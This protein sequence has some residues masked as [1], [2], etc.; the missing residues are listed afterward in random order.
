[1]KRITFVLIATMVVVLSCKKD[2]M[3]DVPMEQ[4]TLTIENV[5][6]PK[7]FFDAG[8]TDGIPPGGSFSFTFNAGKGH[9]LSFATMLA[10]SNDLFYAFQEKGIALYDGSGNAVTGNVT[11]KVY[12]WD[13]GT[14]VNEEPGTGPNQAPR[15]S[16]PD[17]GEDEDGNVKLISDV[18]DGF[19]YPVV[20]GVIKVMISHDGG[21]EFTVTIYN[22]SD[23]A[24]L[25]SPLAPGVW[26]VHAN[27]VQLFTEG[28]PSSEGLEKLAEDGNNS[29]LGDFL[30][31]NAGLVSPFAPGVYAVY[32]GMNPI[33]IPGEEASE[34]LEAL[35]ED[36]DVSMFDFSGK[37]T[38]SAWGTFMTPVD[39]SGPGPVFPGQKYEVSFKASAG[40]VLSF[41]TML[42][43]TNDVFVAPEGISLFGDGI[44]L[45]GD[46]TG[47]LKLW[48][49]KT[50]ANEYPGAG[51]YQA[52]R[53]PGPNTGTDE[54]GTVEV[55]NDGYT[56]P[57]L[58]NMI[59]VTISSN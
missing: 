1:M 48:D 14:E 27:D 52:P 51:M 50:E 20:S 15:Q 33:F 25:T 8:T 41:A 9:Y 42:V 56:Y 3:D 21:T 55:V 22:M 45:S 37:P 59:R 34:A 23:M 11:D 13:A 39:G 4:F 29:T 47:H 30:K 31:M 5:F 46:I 32:H 40:E 17:T 54:T 12:L 53:Q 18:N 2:G 35:A 16:G 26:V 44:P 43:Q 10:Q 7:S 36:G 49:A 6:E 38:I 58:S 19:M 57:D 24:S 28:Q